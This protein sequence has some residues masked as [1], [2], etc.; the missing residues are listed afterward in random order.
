MGASL[1]AQNNLSSKDPG[2]KQLDA[3]RAVVDTMLRQAGLFRTKSVAFLQF[4]AGIKNMIEDDTTL[5]YIVRQQS[6][7]FLEAVLVSV[8]QRLLAEGGPE[9]A[10]VRACAAACH[11]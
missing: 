8:K 4:R 9:F 2:P 1:S 11:L 3:T 6:P 5:H 7:E 10:K